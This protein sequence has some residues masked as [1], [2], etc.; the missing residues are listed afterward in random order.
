MLKI[1]FHVLT[2]CTQIYAF[3]QSL[4]DSTRILLSHVNVCLCTE[5]P[6]EGNSKDV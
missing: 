5:K 3:T 6:R 2:F 4:D 1:N